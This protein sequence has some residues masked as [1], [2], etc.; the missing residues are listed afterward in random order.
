[1][2]NLDDK[3]VVDLQKRNLSLPTIDLDKKEKVIEKSTKFKSTSANQL[4]EISKRDFSLNKGKLFKKRSDK[5]DAY[6]KKQDAKIMHLDWPSKM[7][8]WHNLKDQ[9]PAKN[10]QNYHLIGRKIKNTDS[11]I[12][13]SEFFEPKTSRRNSW[14]LRDNKRKDS[15]IEIISLKQHSIKD[16]QVQFFV[17]LD[18]SSPSG[19]EA[20]KSSLKS[21]SQK[22]S[23]TDLNQNLIESDDKSVDDIDGFVDIES[24]MS[25]EVLYQVEDEQDENGLK[26]GDF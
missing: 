16:S 4:D 20:K 25:L 26:V 11:V 13:D 7:K 9:L 14:W 2:E 5:D 21:E 17:N 12:C 18:D 10:H 6:L 8:L 1:M 22:S 23:K 19:D 3:N 24:D 15:A